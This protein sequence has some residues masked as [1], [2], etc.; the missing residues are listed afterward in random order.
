MEGET[1]SKVRVNG[2]GYGEGTRHEQCLTIPGI[3]TRL[4]PKVELQ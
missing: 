2:G 4:Q 3:S 1:V